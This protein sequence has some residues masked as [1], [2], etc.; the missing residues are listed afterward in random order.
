MFNKDHGFNKVLYFDL[1]LVIINN[2]DKFFHHTS[3]KFCICQDFN[4]QFM[5]NYH[6]SNSSVMKFKANDY[7]HLWDDWIKDPAQYINKHRGDQD[8]LTTYFQ[9]NEHNK[10]WWPREWAMSWKWEID[11]GGK[12][13]NGTDRNSY[14]EPDR[15]FVIPD[16]CSVVVCHGDPKPADLEAKLYKE[17]IKP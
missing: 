8:Y 16:Q 13:N 17:W 12:R 7:Y 3:N 11:R 6:V 2:I 9:Q 4:R 10:E 1:D 14:Y 5:P 15:D